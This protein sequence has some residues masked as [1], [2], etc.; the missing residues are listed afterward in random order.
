MRLEGVRGLIR[1]G[2]I[3]F[4]CGV[5]LFKHGF[6]K[7]F[8]VILR[9]CESSIRPVGYGDKNIPVAPPLLTSVLQGRG[10]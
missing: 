5:V 10:T 7:P 8:D 4:Y 6:A 9:T 3:M 1:C 2:V